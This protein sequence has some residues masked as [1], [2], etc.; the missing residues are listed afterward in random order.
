MGFE[1]MAWRGTGKKRAGAGRK[2]TEAQGLYFIQ[3]VSVHKCST[4]LIIRSF[5]PPWVMA[6]PTYILVS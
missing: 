1:L 6:H 5:N 2:G 3:K 4:N